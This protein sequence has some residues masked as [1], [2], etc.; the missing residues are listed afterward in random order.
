MSKSISS[1]QISKLQLEV[2]DSCIQNRLLNFP[3]Q[4]VFQSPLIKEN[5]D[6][7]ID[8]WIKSGKSFSLSSFLAMN[9]FPF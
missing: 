4:S 5:S 7:F 2:L 8:K 3:A 1:S 6:V 9:H